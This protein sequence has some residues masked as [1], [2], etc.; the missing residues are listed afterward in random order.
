MDTICELNLDHYSNL[1][2]NFLRLDILNSSTNFVDDWNAI[3]DL[4][5]NIEKRVYLKNDIEFNVDIIIFYGD[6]HILDEDRLGIIEIFEHSNDST[7]KKEAT[8]KALYTFLRWYFSDIR[9]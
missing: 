5:Y 7:S 6:C 8:I 1:C 2:H 9:I 3:M 4:I